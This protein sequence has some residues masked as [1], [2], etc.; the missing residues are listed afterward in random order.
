[1]WN[2]EKSP[3]LGPP[4]SRIV[5]L[6]LSH[7]DSFHLPPTTRL[8]PLLV[9]LYCIVLSLLVSLLQNTTSSNPRPLSSTDRDGNAKAWSA[10]LLH[11][12]WCRNYHIA[13]ATDAILCEVEQ[14]L[15]C[16]NFENLFPSKKPPT[17]SSSLS[18]S[19]LS[20]THSL[21]TS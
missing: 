17:R 13:L 14:G 11:R 20:F 9:Y 7:F 4:S 1:M 10:R 5:E 15:S 21:I 12:A 8:L 2:H 18:R 19:L 16:L 3:S 6:S